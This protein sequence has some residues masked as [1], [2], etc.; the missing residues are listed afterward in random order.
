MMHHTITVC[1]EFQDRH[2]KVGRWPEIDMIRLALAWPSRAP[3]VIL[4]GHCIIALAGVLE[5]LSDATME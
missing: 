5:C 4:A 1:A 3:T 2:Q